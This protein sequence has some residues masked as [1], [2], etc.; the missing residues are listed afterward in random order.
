MEDTFHSCSNRTHL[1]YSYLEET[2][3]CQFHDPHFLYYE[4]INFFLHIHRTIQ[5]N[6]GAI[7]HIT[8][9]VLQPQQYFQC[10]L[11]YLQTAQ[12][13]ICRIH[14]IPRIVLQNA[15]VLILSRS[16]TTEPTCNTAL[17]NFM[18]I[19]MKTMQEVL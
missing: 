7:S 17:F 15:I 2:N 3:C 12:V 14:I 4:A 9:L 6:R 19:M 8:P 5:N 16:N 11:P 1:Q 13:I 10:I 18:V